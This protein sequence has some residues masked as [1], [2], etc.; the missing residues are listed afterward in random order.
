VNITHST[1]RKEVIRTGQDR[2]D[3]TGRDR[4]GQNGTERDRTGQDGTE[5]DRTGRDRMGQDRMGQDRMGQDRPDGTGR[6]GTGR[7]Q[8][9][10]TDSAE[11][12]FLSEDQYCQLG[13]G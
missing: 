6:D 2:P 1:R 7:S 11:I 12:I 3:G 13:W 9:H 4:T 8:N 5:R 10:I